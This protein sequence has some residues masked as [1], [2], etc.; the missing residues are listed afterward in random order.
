M[1]R[2]V[3]FYIIALLQMMVGLY[4]VMTGAVWFGI[5]LFG[6][7]LDGPADPNVNFIVSL[8]GVGLGIFMFALAGAFI[9][10]KNW[11]WTATLILQ[12]ISILRELLAVGFG[13]TSLGI[14]SIVLSVIIIFYLFRP[15][16]RSEFA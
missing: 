5:N 2:P 16:V 13:A 3:G 11:A 7:L 10:G 9:N 4:L 14:G 8:V 6:I 1:D 15:K 12:I